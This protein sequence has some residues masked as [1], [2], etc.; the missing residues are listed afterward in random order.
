MAVAGVPTSLG[1][2][3]FDWVQLLHLLWAHIVQVLLVLRDPR[4]VQPCGSVGTC[5]PP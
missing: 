2:V 4:G 5:I 1:S 3:L